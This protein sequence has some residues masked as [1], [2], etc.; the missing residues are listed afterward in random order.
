MR[1][2]SLINFLYE[3][4]EVVKE[5]KIEKKKGNRLKIDAGL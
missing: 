3:M 5:K 2:L 4:E 1:T